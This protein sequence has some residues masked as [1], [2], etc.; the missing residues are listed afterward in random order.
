MNWHEIRDGGNEW[1]QQRIDDAAHERLA[2]RVA[3][4][5]PLQAASG[6]RTWLA[7]A[8]V[9]GARRLDSRFDVPRYEAGGKEAY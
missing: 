9:A 5:A 2:R 3:Q 1:H 8:L 7:M 6:L 4:G